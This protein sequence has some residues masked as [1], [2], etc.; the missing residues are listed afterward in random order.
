MKPLSYFMK[1]KFL[2]FLFALAVASLSVPDSTANA[3]LVFTNALRANFTFT[4]VEGNVL[5]LPTDALNFTAVGALTFSLSD[6]D[7]TSMAFTD[8]T[9]GFDVTGPVGFEGAQLGPFQFESGQLQDIVL[10]GGNNIISANVV[11]LRM[12]WEMEF[13]GLRFYTKDSLPFNGS[14]TGTPFGLDDV[15][16]G[17][18][19]FDVFLDMGNVATD[20]LVVIGSNRFLTAVPEPGS[21]ILLMLGG[22]GATGFRRHWARRS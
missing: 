12:F 21:V 5:D 10:D 2:S 11:D 17:P 13:N 14:I 16:S 8:V 22:F 4:P 1:R 6:I 18:L 20:P 7:S 3:D 15:L 9:G 19:E